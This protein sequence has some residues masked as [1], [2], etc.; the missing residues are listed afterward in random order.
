V[1]EA[2]IRG[3]L[4]KV[5]KAKKVLEHL[6]GRASERAADIDGFLASAQ[7]RLAEFWA[8]LALLK[9]GENETVIRERRERA[10]S[11]LRA[12]Q[13]HYE[14]AFAAVGYSWALIQA[15]ALTF[16]RTGELDADAWK[17]G[18]LL[19]KR[20]LNLYSDERR[21]FAINNLIELALLASSRTL[22]SEPPKEV[23]ELVEDPRGEALFWLDNLLASQSA[24]EWS[25][26]SLRRQLLRYRETF[27]KIPQQ[28]KD[29]AQVLS[30]RLDQ[31]QSGN[32]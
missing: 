10:D 5:E 14:D 27:S 18:W 21:T 3:P 16:A 13:R 2:R 25:T 31:E 11:C 12:A 22:W 17:L 30:H 7:K 26:H 19:S 20:E 23:T 24:H 6:R 4:V 9:T 32:R 28:V 29:L 15:L 1:S 8:R